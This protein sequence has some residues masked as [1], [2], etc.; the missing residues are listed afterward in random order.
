MKASH[1][2]WVVVAMLWGVALL[3]YLDRQVVFSMFPPLRR[4]LGFSNVELGLLSTVFLWPYAVLSPWAAYLGE[5][6]GRAHHRAKLG[7]MEP[8]YFGH[9]TRAQR[10]EYA[11]RAGPAGH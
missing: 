4:D 11:Y 2:A 3:N 5:R 10:G 8:G 1:F 6:L 9:G 7:G